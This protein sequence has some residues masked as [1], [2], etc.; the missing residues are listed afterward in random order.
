MIEFHASRRA[1]QVKARETKIEWLNIVLSAGEPFGEL[2]ADD[3]KVEPER[4]DPSCR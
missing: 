2:V 4:K 1:R 3:S